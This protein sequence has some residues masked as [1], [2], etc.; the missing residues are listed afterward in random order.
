MNHIM[1]RGRW[2]THSSVERYSKPG[3]LQA[4]WVSKPPHVRDFLVRC[5]ENLEYFLA[6]NTCPPMPGI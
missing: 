1:K 6:T 4:L 2:K 5:T 3:N